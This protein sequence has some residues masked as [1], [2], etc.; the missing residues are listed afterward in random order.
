MFGACWAEV[1][2]RVLGGVCGV[3]VEAWCWGGCH[4][5]RLGEGVLEVEGWCDTRGFGWG[6]GGAVAGLAT[7]SSTRAGEGG[8]CAPPLSC[9]TASVLF[10]GQPPMIDLVK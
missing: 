10:P 9:D 6:V 2:A 3:A 8:N 5:G 7:R 1:R 4:G